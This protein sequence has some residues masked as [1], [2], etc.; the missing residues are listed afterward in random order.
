MKI[1]KCSST[2][3]EG[4]CDDFSVTA[5]TAEVSM[6]KFGEHAAEAHADMMASSTEEDKQKWGE[7]FKTVWANTPDDAAGEADTAEA[8]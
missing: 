5:E 4:G 3:P 7:N 1:I 6:Q 2:V 8:G